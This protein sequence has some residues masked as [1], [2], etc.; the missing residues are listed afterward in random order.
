[1]TCKPA[2]VEKGRP[3]ST[4]RFSKPALVEKGQNPI[5]SF[6]LAWKPAL[7]EKGHD[8][9]GQT[10]EAIEGDVDRPAKRSKA[11]TEEEA[12]QEGETEDPDGQG[13]P[14]PTKRGEE[15]GKERATGADKI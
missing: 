5:G 7:V 13:G 12:E 3:G 2:L 9:P 6:D 11:E 4:V 14:L 10:M 1:M 15:T 8:R